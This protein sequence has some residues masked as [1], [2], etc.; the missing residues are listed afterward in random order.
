[1]TSVQGIGNVSFER[2]LETIQERCCACKMSLSQMKNS[3][4]ENLGNQ[5]SQDSLHLPHT[6]YFRISV[7]GPGALTS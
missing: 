3:V 6:K 1:M 4:T 2:S 7:R 5:G